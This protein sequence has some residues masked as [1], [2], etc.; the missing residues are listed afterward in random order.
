MIG[1]RAILQG[2]GAI[3][4]AAVLEP[5]VALARTRGPEVWELVYRDP[6]TWLPSQDWIAT[7]TRHDDGKRVILQ[8]LPTAGPNT[9]LNVMRIWRTPDR[10]WY[11]LE[12]GGHEFD[13]QRVRG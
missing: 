4:G 2:L 7:V 6:G 13:R 5:V 11:R 9:P 3:V 1:R 12:I 10:L 8:A